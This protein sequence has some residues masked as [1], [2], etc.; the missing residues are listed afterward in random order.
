MCLFQWRGFFDRSDRTRNVTSH[1]Q[2]STGHKIILSILQST[3]CSPR[4]YNV[5]SCGREHS[6]HQRNQH[7]YNSYSHLLQYYCISYTLKK[8]TPDRHNTERDKREKTK[9]VSSTTGYYRSH[10]SILLNSAHGKTQNNRT[11]APFI[12]FINII[13]FNLPL[14]QRVQ[15]IL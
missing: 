6:P 5:V 4:T 14:I 10:T 13:Y 2:H 11:E 1:L 7:P 9:H 15:Y 12:F 3:V 8:S